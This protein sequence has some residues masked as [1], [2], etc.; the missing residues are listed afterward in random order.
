VT[1]GDGPDMSDWGAQLIGVLFGSG[2]GSNSE[3][4]DDSSGDGSSVGG[5]D[6]AMAQGEAV[7]VCLDH[8][9]IG[10]SRQLS[11]WIEGSRLASCWSS[12]VKV[13]SHDALGACRRRDAEGFGAMCL[14]G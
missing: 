1:G 8:P 4:G 10:P 6:P 3:D 9:T 12:D 11:F 7:G 5:G 2:D 13:R 14:A